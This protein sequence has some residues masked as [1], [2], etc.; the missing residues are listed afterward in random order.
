MPDILNEFLKLI[1]GVAAIGA[2]SS[3][4]AYAMFR[5][6][7][8]KWIETR[9]SER[10]E[11][12]KHQ[13]NQEIE[14][15]RFRINTMM[16]WNVKLHQREFDILPETWSLLNEAFYT[17]E[18]IAIGFQQYPNLDEM[19]ADRLEEFL[20]KSPLTVV[21]KTELKSE[22]NKIEYYRAVKTMHDLNTAIDSYNQF[23]LLLAK[24]AIFIVEP[25]KTAF[26]ALDQMLKEAIIERQVQPQKFDK[27]VMLNDKGKQLLKALEQG[28]QGRLWSSQDSKT[29]HQ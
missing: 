19:S 23:H 4:F 26:L 15:L 5:L 16:D 12:F 18:P 29:E 3:A 11:A 7:T 22:S 28:I 14:H 8:T 2:A 20:E 13:Q 1:G 10:L 9:F 17:I 25:I 21:R 6:F 27:G 24:N